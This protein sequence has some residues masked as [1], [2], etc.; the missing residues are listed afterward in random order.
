MTQLLLRT[1]PSFVQGNFGSQGCGGRSEVRSKLRAGRGPPPP[2]SMTLSSTPSA[3]PVGPRVPA[4]AG[5]TICAAQVC[6]GPAQPGASRT[7]RR[8]WLRAPA[9]QL[10]SGLP[11]VRAGGPG[12]RGRAPFKRCQGLIDEKCPQQVRTCLRRRRR[13]GSGGCFSGSAAVAGSLPQWRPWGIPGS[14]EPGWAWRLR[15]G[16]DPHPFFSLP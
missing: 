12:R 4:A 14:P 1:G 15:Q 9:G 16:G 6:P 7:Q 8:L 2:R 10:R 3:A 13:P 5:D 11:S